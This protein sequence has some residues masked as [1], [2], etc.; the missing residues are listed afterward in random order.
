KI[1]S[2]SNGNSIFLPDAGYRR[3]TSLNYAGSCCSYWSC[4]GY[5]G[6]AFG[7]FFD[8]CSITAGY[9]YIYYGRSVRPVRVQK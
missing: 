9:Y 7:L 8:S 5:S 1:T 6:F 2:K 4:T 3:D